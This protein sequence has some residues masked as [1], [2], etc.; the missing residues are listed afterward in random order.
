MISLFKK[1][2]KKVRRVKKGGGRFSKKESLY[3][4]QHYSPNTV[5][6]LATKLGRA[7]EAVYKQYQKEVIRRWL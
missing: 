5:E 3:I 4:Y 2:K 6:K 1:K 7:P